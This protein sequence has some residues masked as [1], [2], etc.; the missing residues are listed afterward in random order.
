LPKTG[1]WHFTTPALVDGDHTFTVQA[2]DAAKNTSQPSAGFAFTLDTQAPNAPTLTSVRDNIGTIKGSVVNNGS[3]DDAQLLLQGLAEAGLT[4]EL[5]DD[6]NLLGSVMAN[7]AG[8]WRFTTSELTDGSHSFSAKA[9]DAAGNISVASA[10]YTVTVDTQAPKPPVIQFALDNMGSLTGK[11]VNGGVT[12]DPI[13]VVSGQAEAG[14]TVTLFDHAL[15][16][17]STTSNQAGHWAIVTPTLGDGDHTLTAH[18]VDAV[19][20]VSSLSKAFTITVDDTLAPAVPVIHRVQDDIG[21][22]KGF[23]AR[24]GVTDDTT[25]V[26]QGTAEAGGTVEVFDG[27]T[28]LGTCQ[29]D[30][31]GQWS[32]TPSAMKDGSHQFIAQVTDAAKNTSGPSPAFVM[33]VDTQAPDVPVIRAVRDH[34]GLIAQKGSTD[35]NTLLLTGTSEVGSTV[36]VFDGSHRLGSV[37]ANQSGQWSLTTLPLTENARH[38]FHVMATDSAG[39]TSPSSDN[40]QVTIDTLSPTVTLSSNKANLKAGETIRVT[41][42]FSETPLDFTAKDIV[43]TGGKLSDLK[44]GRTDKVYTALFTP[45]AANHFNGSIQVAGSSYTDPAGNAGASS[46]TLNLSGDTLAPRVIISGI[47]N[48]DGSGVATVTFTFSETPIGFAIDDIKVNG[49]SLSHLTVNPS[50]N[51][52]YTALFTPASDA[53]TLPGT[54]VVDAGLFTDEAGN[55]GTASNLLTLLN[56]S[57]SSDQLGDII[58][59]SLTVSSDKTSF[60]TGEIATVTFTFSEA[61]IGFTLDD[62][63]VDGGRLSDL[64]VNSSDHR[65]YTALFTPT[66]NV[67][68]FKGSISVAANQYTDSAGTNG[69]ASNVLSLTGDTQAPSLMISSNKTNLKAG[70]TATVTFRFSETPLGFTADDIAVSGGKLSGLK[71]DPTDGKVYTALYTPT[72]NTNGLEGSVSVAAGQFTDAIGNAGLASN[73]L[74]LTGDTLAP[75][76]TISANKTSFKAGETATVTFRFSETPLGF[77]ADDIAVSGGKLSGLKVDPTDGK[78]YTALYTPTANTNGLEGSVSVAAG[79]FTDAI[80]NAGLA[81]NSLSLTGDTLAPSLTISSNKTN[82]KAG[83]TATVTFRFSEAPTDFTFAD[84]GVS[85]GGSLTKLAVSPAD[86]KVYTALYTP[87][88]TNSLTGS[89]SVPAGSFT[90]VIGN[91]GTVNNSLS[92]SGDTLAPTLT[93]TSNTSNLSA[94][95]TATITF[96]FSEAPIGFD[97][98]D[99]TVSG[100]SLGTL[101]GVG[102]TRTATFTPI[103]NAAGTAAIA[104][105]SGSYTDLAGNAGGA[106]ALSNLSYSTLPANTGNNAGTSGGSSGGSG[107][108]TGGG[109]S[110]GSSGGPGGST[111]GGT[112]GGSSG[113]SGGGTG[114]GTSGGSSGGSGG[115]TGGGTS[116]GSS[117]SSGDDTLV[118]P[119][120]GDL[121]IDGGLGNDQ[122]RLANGTN[123]VVVSNIETIIGGLNSDT[124][125]VTSE[126]DVTVDGGDGD[127]SLILINTGTNVVT[128]ANVEKIVGGDGTNIITVTSS[129]SITVDGGGNNLGDN[130]SFTYNADGSVV[131][132]P[133][134]TSD[135]LILTASDPTTVNTVSVAHVE[136]I[137]GSQGRDNITVTSPGLIAVDGGS[138]G[139]DSLTLTASTYSTVF[140][141]HIESI[142]SGAG[143]DL[144]MVSAAQTEGI[145]FTGSGGADTIVLNPNNNAVDRIVFTSITDGSDW[146]SSYSNLRFDDYDSVQG[147]DSTDPDVFLLSNAL[148]RTIGN[149]DTSYQ[150]QAVNSGS[151]DLVAGN[152]NASDLYYIQNRMASHPRDIN[153]VIASIGPLIHDDTSGEQ[154]LFLVQSYGGTGLYA[155]RSGNANGA[156]EAGELR[157]IGLIAAMVD[158][159]DFAALGS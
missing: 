110:G 99:I 131:V 129:G 37:K 10:D 97:S 85:G 43:V 156:I 12:D 148:L 91:V 2:T 39:N 62:V 26:L 29:V 106:A 114:G 121:T 72:A 142:V 139:S 107:G 9:R 116:G 74:S 125:T 76:L 69:L 147:F 66:A 130:L 95:Q 83:E 153:S 52:V 113:G 138:G 30:A 68:D 1:A 154:T 119:S 103:S 44:L 13:L 144:I 152:N 35:D 111:G 14:S 48:I 92:L 134:S 27:K 51:K 149:D 90:D 59:P 23:I 82:L 141:N 46:N 108:S 60:K 19:G 93:I 98:G 155:F 16:L 109:T 79:Q 105:A 55:L 25:P 20:Q 126:G 11:I 133:G 71:V 77:T 120:P 3:T 5:Y 145:T 137:V 81:S 135:K 128:V 6:G 63:T 47:T 96:A 57:K 8:Q 65:V 146:G 41:V 45:D 31:N 94:G 127:D 100:G 50:D 117:G 42:T 21:K 38:F 104:V 80:G 18:S 84:I 22:V 33:T 61:P 67:N 143:S 88:V 70:E 140:V 75:S 58:V 7:K 86:N 53:S 89:I 4:V 158:D 24:N 132:N 17:G 40:Y 124:I 34:Q 73:S 78:V 64:A 150:G 101:G 118:I 54:I 36:E 157:M 32:F 56:E 115:G 28:S 122:L 87:A 159:G 49:G 112:S 15:S 102:L 123:T 151:V 136:L